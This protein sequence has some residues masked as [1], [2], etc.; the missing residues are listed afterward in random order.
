[1]NGAEHPQR[2]P[3]SPQAPKTKKRPHQNDENGS[4]V[5]ISKR[6]TEKKVSTRSKTK[7][8]RTNIDKQPKK[9]NVNISS[10]H[11]QI[12][13]APEAVM[14][15]SNVLKDISNAQ[16]T[17][18]METHVQNTQ[19]SAKDQ[20]N[21]IQNYGSSRNTDKEA[22]NDDMQC[23]ESQ[24]ENCIPEKQINSRVDT[25]RRTVVDHGVPTQ[26]LSELQCAYCT[27]I[28]SIRPSGYYKTNP[29]RGPALRCKMCTRNFQGRSVINLLHNAAH[30]PVVFQALQSAERWIEANKKIIAEQKKHQTEEIDWIQLAVKEHRKKFQCPRCQAVGRFALDK[31][32]GNR[33][34]RCTACRKF[35]SGEAADYVVSSALGTKWKEQILRENNAIRS[36]ENYDNQGHRTSRVLSTKDSNAKGTVEMKAQH[37]REERVQIVAEK[38]GQTGNP[39]EDQSERARETSITEQVARISAKVSKETSEHEQ[40]MHVSSRDWNSLVQTIKSMESTI[41][42][43]KTQNH[44]LTEKIEQLTKNQAEY[45]SNLSRSNVQ[46]DVLRNNHEWPLLQQSQGENNVDRN[47]PHKQITPHTEKTA[48]TWS[49]VVRQE[50]MANLPDEQRVKIHQTLSAINTSNLR[51]STTPITDV[52]YVK[53]LRRSPYGIVR[54]SL[55]HS[56]P[57]AGLLGLSYI[58]G[59]I[60]EIVTTKSEKQ[61]LIETI[62]LLGLQHMPSFAITD[63]SLK[64]HGEISD[65]KQREKQ[66][67]LRIVRRMQR[68]VRNS[69]NGLATRWYAARLKEANDRLEQLL[70]EEKGTENDQNRDTTITE[71]VHVPLNVIHEKENAKSNA[72]FPK[73]IHKDPNVNAPEQVRSTAVPMQRQ[74]DKPDVM[75]PQ[76]S[77]S[78][79]TYN[80]RGLHTKE[81]VVAEWIQRNGIAV[82]ALTETWLKPG[83]ELETYISEQVALQPQCPNGKGYGGVAL[84]VHPLLKYELLGKEANSVYQ[85]VAI[86]AQ[87]VSTVGLYLSPAA[88]IQ[89]T[90][91]CLHDIEELISL[92]FI[93]MGDLNARHK[94]WDK[95]DNTRGRFLRKHAMQRAWVIN[96]PNEATRIPEPNARR[97]S[98]TIDMFIARGI[99]LRRAEVNNGPWDGCS[100]HRPISAISDTEWPMNGKNQSRKVSHLRRI[101][102]ELLKKAAKTFEEKIP[103]IT[104][105]IHVC[106]SVQHFESIMKKLEDTLL[107]PWMNAKRWT[108]GKPRTGWS[109]DIHEWSKQRSKAYRRAI[110]TKRVEDWKVY[111]DLDKKIKRKAKQLRERRVQETF[112]QLAK[113]STTKS[114]QMLSHITRERN[115]RISAALHHGSMLKHKDFAAFVA[116]PEGKGYVPN[117]QQFELDAKFYDHVITSIREAENGK[118]TGPD[119][120]FVEALKTQ[121]ELFATLLVEIWSKCGKLCYMPVSWR[122]ARLVP[123]HKK[124]DTR[125]PK[126]Y[127][128]ITVISQLRKVVD[129]AI[130][131]SIRA[132]F[133]FHPAQLGFR[134]NVGI[135]NAILRTTKMQHMGMRFTAVLDLRKAYD[136]VPRDKLMQLVNERLPKD[137]A[138]M[139]AYILQ[140]TILRDR[141]NEEIENMNQSYEVRIGVPQGDPPSTTLFNMY[142]DLYAEKVMQTTEHYR[143]TGGGLIMFADDVKLQARTKT[144]LQNML[145]MSTTWASEYKMTWGLPKCFVLQSQNGTPENFKLAGQSVQNVSSVEYLGVQL[146]A[147]GITEQRTVQRCEAAH[148]KLQELKNIGFWSQWLG[149]I[150][151]IQLCKLVILPIAEYAIHLTPHSEMLQKKYSSVQVAIRRMII[152]TVARRD[153]ARAQKLLQLPPLSYRKAILLSHLENRLERNVSCYDPNT[154]MEIIARED[155]AALRLHRRLFALPPNSSRKAL[156]CMWSRLCQTVARPMPCMRQNEFVPILKLKSSSLRNAGVGWYFNRFP[157]Q[158]QHTITPIHLVRRSAWSYRTAY[159]NLKKKMKQTEWTPEEVKSVERAIETIIVVDDKALRNGDREG[160]VIEEDEFEDKNSEEL[161]TRPVRGHQALSKVNSNYIPSRTAKLSRFEQG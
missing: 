160:L 57:R 88:T 11:E 17:D 139:I 93:I 3:P 74:S 129:K 152:A 32:N 156:Q 133:T 112:E 38:L 62:Q 10:N 120:V 153:E 124:G 7:E 157:L 86:K 27:N 66:N 117:M 25:T 147:E 1:M 77:F 26:V 68:C 154:T 161:P 126:N 19:K 94:D 36:S 90:R 72:T 5:P 155:L 12:I 35:L 150:R 14:F 65:K 110:R 16:G 137:I 132:S 23:S 31:S 123:I 89:Q 52:V 97:E 114:S 40:S 39:V 44:V 121:P 18:T 115:R 79:G 28:G 15:D 83:D 51:I 61:N 96:T 151:T 91:E 98:S 131:K 42:A 48:R 50:R 60:L 6:R 119:E 136:S 130:D 144:V 76:R 37:G 140:P 21:P 100:D 55:L 127:R 67:L 143:N 122:T 8:I 148:L 43:L 47:N 99:R 113:N 95:K 145:D 118:S 78:V 158:N 30:S 125:N 142:M 87:G 13:P 105:E 103:N 73:D 159:S 111:K 84:C 58:G 92:P 80:V 49:N 22:H 69:R 81:Q 134:P 46:V 70:H 109:K 71:D 146:S 64:K 33:V 41:I 75:A 116:T 128:P 102:P 104:K 34:M 63:D 4:L 149:V 138:R 56:I 24:K 9:R 53:G 29:Y 85:Y 107:Q 59:S 20:L 2:S 106:T 54:K 141:E 82:A 135:E 108:P 45:Q 101:Q